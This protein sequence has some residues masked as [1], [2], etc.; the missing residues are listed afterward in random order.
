MN[1]LKQ[2]AIKI[3]LQALFRRFNEFQIEYSAENELDMK[4]LIHFA[5][6]YYIVSLQ[7]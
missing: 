5:V 1:S 4:Y 6:R 7:V 2:T 3:V